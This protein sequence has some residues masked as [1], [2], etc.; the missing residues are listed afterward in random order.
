MPYNN[1]P[2]VAATYVDGNLRQPVF[3][4]QP[5]ILILAPASNGLT[6]ERFDVSNV[7]QAEV[8]FGSSSEIA[9]A[10]HEVYAQ[11]A[12]NISLMRIGGKK[13]SWVFEDSEGAT[14]T[15]VPQ[16]RDAEI[17]ERY[18][19]I[20][21]TS[22][23]A[24]RI[25]VYDLQDQEWV[26]DSLE[27]LVINEGIVDVDDTGIDL[28]TVG[29]S[30]DPDAADSLADLVT[31]DFT[32][33]GTATAASVDID[34]GAD[35]SNVSLVEKYAALE[36]AYHNLDFQDADFVLPKGVY[37]D[38]NNVADG[39][40]CNFFKGVPVAGGVNDSLGYVWQMEYQGTVYTY[41]TDS[42]TYF[43]T[44]R[45]AATVTVN[46]TLVVPA[47]KAGTG[48]N[49][50]SIQVNAAGAAG[51]TVTITE[52]AW[53]TLHILVTDDG[54]SD[55]ADAAAAINLATAAYVMS[56]GQLASTIVG[57]ATGGVTLLTTVASTS[58][59]TGTGSH[60][61]THEDLTGDPIPSAVS[62]AFAAADTANLDSQ[63]REV[64]FA[65]QL[66]TFCRRASTTWHVIQGGIS[67]KAPTGYSRNDL[68]S[69]IGSPPSETD[70]GT[71]K[72]IDAPADNGTGLFSIK[73]MAGRSV[74]SNGYRAHMIEDGNST[75]GYLYGGLI[76]TKGA[77]LPN[78]DI[79]L[80]YGIEDGD[81]AVDIN[82]YP[83]DIGKHI[84]VTVDWPI[85]RNAF[86]GGL[87]YRGSIEACLIGR[88]ATMPE[89]E[90]PIG[91]DYP[92]RKITSV[93]RI[94]ASQRD[95]LSKFRFNNLRFEEGVGYVFNSVRTAAHKLDSDYTRCS[96]VRCVNRHLTG[97]RNIAR[98][99]LGK[100]FSPQRLA[101]LQSSIDSYL[102]SERG[103]GFNQGAAAQLSYTRADKILGKLEV[104][105]R[106]VPPFTIERID[107]VMSL[108]AE[109]SE[110]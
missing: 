49:N 43:T 1:T 77:S 60:I 41:F 88:L 75:D 79:D 81:E 76:A 31:G 10:M 50:I 70:I 90:E 89:N 46:T 54:T 95:A 30:T 56:N 39:D 85:H 91:R 25:L 99:Y 72:A 24:N 19:L 27:T 51:P 64:N 93:P 71:D 68:A 100:P 66:A 98:N 35:G 104:R 17:L 21:E 14:L 3:T 94:H 44:A 36:R 55:T 110:L 42:A 107:S 80:A 65:H 23:G 9:K 29:D 96:T 82:G 5:K 34:A 109:E 20:I 103:N 12:D 11:G 18:A 52:P 33:V 58:L 73:L 97:I 84:H 86:N 40:T 32:V 59:S 67:V 83:V 16:Y 102:A 106:M 22:G 6:D 45:S 8:E 78:Q 13:A 62:T 61:L 74:S 57:T 108:A 105:L 38:D 47:A 26:F 7:G 101:S 28:F 53:N 63:L 4:T 92:L 2:Q 69:W 48:G 87:N 37:I 15:I